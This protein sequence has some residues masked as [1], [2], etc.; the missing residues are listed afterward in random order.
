MPRVRAITRFGQFLAFKEQKGVDLGPH[1][2]P[3]LQRM[4][5]N[6]QKVS[7]ALCEC[8]QIPKFLVS[9]KESTP[10]YIS[11]TVCTNEAWW[12]A[13]ISP[14]HHNEVVRS[15]HPLKKT[16]PSTILPWT[17]QFSLVPA[18]TIFL[19]YPTTSTPSWPWKWT[20]NLSFKPWVDR[21]HSWLCE[22]SKMQAL[23]TETLGGLWRWSYWCF[24]FGQ[25]ARE[26]TETW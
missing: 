10:P 13:S 15:C 21:V 2:Q 7:N 26:E 20:I 3:H 18:S 14:K 22:A 11:E 17:P 19:K 16:N 23:L 24:V 12:T 4:N 6:N 8:I 25:F 9:M 5:H 1:T